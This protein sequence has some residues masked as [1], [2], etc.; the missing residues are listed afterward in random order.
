MKWALS[1]LAVPVLYLLSVPPLSNDAAKYSNRSQK[2]EDF[3]ASYIE[4]YH[5][6][7]GQH[8]LQRPL[9]AY[10]EYWRGRAFDHAMPPP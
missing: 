6:L 7:A 3:L 9:E 2:V 4:P 10:M 1:I 5:W 8:L